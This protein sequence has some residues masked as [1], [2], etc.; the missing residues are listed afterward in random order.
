VSVA[1]D[2]LSVRGGGAALYGLAGGPQGAMGIRLRLGT[3]V[4]FCAA[5]P[6]SGSLPE[7]DSTNR[8]KGERNTAAPA[9]CPAVP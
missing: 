4:E 6:A 7:N 9:P 5:A 3:G 2:R 8:F 1:D